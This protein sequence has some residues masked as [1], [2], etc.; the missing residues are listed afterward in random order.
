MHEG[1]HWTLTNFS[2]SVK[3][4]RLETRKRCPGEPTRSNLNDE[5]GGGGGGRQRSRKKR[6]DRSPSAGKAY[7][8]AGLLCQVRSRGPEEMRGDD[9]YDDDDG[10]GGE[11]TSARNKQQVE[12][13]I[14]LLFSVCFLLSLA[15]SPLLT[16]SLLPG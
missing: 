6:E 5:E 9:D 16:F 10:G 13:R 11:R 7:E 1:N 3:N 14:N 15:A 4:V 2:N 12:A 8:A